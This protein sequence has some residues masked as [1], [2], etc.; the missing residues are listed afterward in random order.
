M[1]AMDGPEPAGPLPS[2]G[3]STLTRVPTIRR[4]SSASNLLTTLN[5]NSSSPASPPPIRDPA[6]AVPETW[7]SQSMFSDTSGGTGPAGTVASSIG[8]LNAGG[9]IPPA[10]TSGPGTSVEALQHVIQRRLQVLTM[11][12]SSHE[13]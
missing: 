11:L 2:A 3:T 12:K 8:L 1:T 13:G 9:T 5:K 10:T 4:K 7:D 6:P